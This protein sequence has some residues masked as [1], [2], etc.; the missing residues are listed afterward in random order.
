MTPGN[1][2][3]TNKGADLSD[4]FTQ[5]RHGLNAAA[6]TFQPR[7]QIFLLS[8]AYWSAFDIIYATFIDKLSSSAQIKRAKNPNAAIRFLDDNTPKAIII[9]DQG[10]NGK[11][12]K[13][14]LD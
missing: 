9:T 12:N 8:L 14:V 6:S 7:P 2:V 3:D 5:S 1:A 11:E 13:H 4:P 10:L